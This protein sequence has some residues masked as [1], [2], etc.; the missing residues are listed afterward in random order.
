LV[1]QLASMLVQWLAMQMVGR[2]V[3][4]MDEL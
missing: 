2:K 1:Q 3:Q 4:R